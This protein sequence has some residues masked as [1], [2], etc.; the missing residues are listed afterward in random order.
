MGSC[1]S[2]SDVNVGW[3]V[4]PPRSPW[5]PCHGPDGTGPSQPITPDVSSITIA[6]CAPDGLGQHGCCV[7]AATD[8]ARRWTCKRFISCPGA[9][10]T[11]A[12]QFRH[13]TH[14]TECRDWSRIGTTW[15]VGLGISLQAYERCRPPHVSWAAWWSGA[16]VVRAAEGGADSM[17]ELR[18]VPFERCHEP[19]SDWWS[20]PVPTT[21]DARRSSTALHLLVTPTS[22]LLTQLPVRDR[23]TIVRFA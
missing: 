14:T 15:P 12:K 11:E 16:R 5:R 13:S 23:F 9:S 3:R 20:V 19:R 6:S 7:V 17:P 4:T 10:H 22:E 2:I 1:A 21:R 18:S 8:R